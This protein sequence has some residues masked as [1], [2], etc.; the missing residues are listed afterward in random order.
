L[1]TWEIRK[2]FV[3]TS[4]RWNVAG[5]RQAGCWNEASRKHRSLVISGSLG[6]R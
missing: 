1:G 3:G 4:M 6:S 5:S 2:V